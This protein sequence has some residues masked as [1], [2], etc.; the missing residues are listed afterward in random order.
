MKKMAIFV[1]G[2][3]ELIFVERLLKEIIGDN[4]LIIQTEIGEGGS[5]RNKPR[6]YRII[7]GQNP[8][9]GAEFY[10]LIVNCGSDTKVVSDIRDRREGLKNGGFQSI[11][12]I[13]D[14]YPNIKRS[15]IQKS[16]HLMEK[17]V[18]IQDITVKI[19]FAIMEIETFFILDGSHFLKTDD[20][21]TSDFIKI[22][23]G[24]DPQTDD[25]EARDKPSVD[26][27]RIYRLVGSSYEKSESAITEIVSKL[28]YDYLVRTAVNRSGSLKYLVDTIQSFI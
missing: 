7:K 16:I 20:R 13:R 21:L 12:G 11:V 4:K 26:L 24:F 25:I 3:T 6:L 2:L 17:R 10:V 22:N 28:D 15:D 27:D 14:V 23:I 18:A 8:R 5:S 19:I 1:E 9:I